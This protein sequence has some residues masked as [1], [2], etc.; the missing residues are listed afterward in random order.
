MKNKKINGFS[1]FEFMLTLM[2]ILIITVIAVPLIL[3]AI[4][5]FRIN[6][7]KN[8]AYNV[9]DAVKYYV[10]NSGF[11]SFPE[12]GIEINELDLELNNNIFD[13]GIVKKTGDNNYQLINLKKNN[14]CATGTLENMKATDKGCGSLDETAP[15]I[16]YIYLKNA[17][18]NSITVISSALEEESELVYFEY[19]IDGSKY[20][21]KTT[22]NE[23]TFTN[24]KAGKHKIKVKITNEANL[25]IVSDE[26]TFSTKEVEN[27]ECYE[28]D[29][30]ESYQI[31]KNYICEYPKGSNFEYQYSN[32]GKNWENISLNENTYTFK[33][34]ENKTLYTRVL[35]DN[36]IKYSVSINVNNIDTTLNG[37]YPELLENMIPV[38]YDSNLNAWVKADS[39]IKYFDY[40]NKIWANAVLVRKSRN[41]T[42]SNSKSR[43]YYLSD[44]AI[45]KPI[46]EGDIIGYYV[47][48]PRFKYT[49]FNVNNKIIDPIEINVE[50]ENTNIQKQL[51]SSNNNYMTHPAFSYDTEVNGFW[52]SKFQTSVDETS[53]C[54]TDKTMCNKEDLILYA[55][56]DKNKITNISISNAW[57]SSQKMI[58]NDNIYGLKDA[59]VNVLT[60][61]EWGAIAYLAN[62]KYGI[63]GN[64]TSNKL[65]YKNNL[66]SSTTGNI[67]GVFD[68]ISNTEMVMANY[69]KDA[70]KD[71]NDNSGFK[72]YSNVDWPSIIDYYSGITNKNKILGDA[73]SETEGWY[74]SYS[75]FVNGAYPFFIR[76]G[77][78]DGK[79]SIYN[80]SSFTGNQT[81]NVSFRT[82]LTKK[83]D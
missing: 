83:G 15:K 12:E 35:Q 33:F 45:S 59:N 2:V 9:I 66:T 81:D 11:D 68:M 29:S 61:L 64:M 47:W 77:K 79:I 34:N 43:E 23:Y 42:D 8:S 78:I 41:T 25:S 26:F 19:S 7:F 1:L 10:A 3:Y 4:K 75:K 31:E 44:E 82:V 36:K 74:N 58:A 39:R 46:Y 51:S 16:A 72:N 49:L 57:L 32:D 54:Y 20:T 63:N 38:I 55:V 22:S 50:F 30:L 28:K 21:K 18:S 48:I 53:S 65:D 27:I 24:L 13:S 69:N 67:T 37:A 40:D 5:A 71:K 60:N 62:S 17:T 76:G 73:T 14:Y 80:Y 56:P 70:G 52:V 6:A